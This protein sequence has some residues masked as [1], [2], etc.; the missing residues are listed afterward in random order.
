MSTTL[1]LEKHTITVWSMNWRN[2]L[3]PCL[4]WRSS[5]PVQLNEKSLLSTL[6]AFDPTDTKI[7]TF[8]LD[9]REPCLLTLVDF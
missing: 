9:S 2:L 1:R 4:Y 8:D 3:Q 5:K 6:G 7:I